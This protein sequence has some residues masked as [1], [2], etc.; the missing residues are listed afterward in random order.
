MTDIQKVVTGGDSQKGATSNTP[1]AVNVPTTSEPS[2]SVP[3]SSA[4]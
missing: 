1:P 2:S 3:P 4:K